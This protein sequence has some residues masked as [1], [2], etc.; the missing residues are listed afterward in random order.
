MGWVG[1]N[2]S[3]FRRY[4]FAVGGLPGKILFPKVKVAGGDALLRR[5]RRR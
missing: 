2:A 3:F 5:T 1:L 4:K